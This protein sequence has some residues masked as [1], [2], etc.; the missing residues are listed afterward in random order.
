VLFNE[1]KMMKIRDES[2]TNRDVNGSLLPTSFSLH[3][4][5]LKMDTLKRHFQR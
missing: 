5:N 2:S 1:A 3:R 4:S